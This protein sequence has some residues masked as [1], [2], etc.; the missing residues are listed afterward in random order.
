MHEI[1][2]VEILETFGVLGRG[3]LE[4]R[5]DLDRARADAWSF[6]EEVM[7]PEIVVE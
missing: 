6:L 1:H 7:K 3:E 5:L 2:F 4:V